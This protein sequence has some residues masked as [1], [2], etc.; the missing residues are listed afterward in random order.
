MT[1]DA[2]FFTESTDTIGGALPPIGAYKCAHVLRKHGYKCLVVRLFGWYSITELKSLMDRAVGNNTC[3]IGFS[4]TFLREKKLGPDGGYQYTELPDDQVF[5]QG[6]QTED[7][8]IDYCLQLNPKIKFLAGG[9]KVGENWQNRNIDYAFIGYSEF[10]IINLMNHLTRNT[11]LKFSR[12]N[13]WGIT[14]IDDRMATSYDFVHDRM[15]W[16]PE[17]VVNAKALPIEIGRG[18]IFKCKFCSYPLNGKKNLDFVKDADL[19]YQELEDN[20]YKYGIT[21]YSI[22]DDTFN[23]HVKKLDLLSQLIQRLSFQPK[24]WAY[25]RLDLICTHPET[26]PMLHNIGVKGLYFGIE[27]LNHKTGRTIGKGFDRN[28]QISMIHHIRDQYPDMFMHGSFIA[29]LPY[30]TVESME[31]TYDMLQNQKI[32]LHSWTVRPLNIYLKNGFASD[33]DQNWKTYGY[34]DLG[35]DSAF[36]AT[37]PATFL[38][39]GNEYTTFEYLKTMTADVMKKSRAGSAMYLSGQLAMAIASLGSAEMSFEN[40]ANTKHGQIDFDKIETEFFLH[41]IEYKRQL[42][43]VVSNPNIELY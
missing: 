13:I 28:R 14:L 7:K 30:E 20:Y 4:T 43:A 21:N 18:C 16:L 12:K 8:F 22:V 23:D 17:D 29:G 37:V 26:L 1:F 34:H 35:K 42:L 3:I 19:L 6:K 31:A 25:H 2:I 36:G 41:V 40:V 11:K 39:W 9:S 32:P 33:I 15:Q 5:P 10:S 27:T 38:N 24:F